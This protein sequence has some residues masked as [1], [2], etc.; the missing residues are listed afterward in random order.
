MAPIPT[1]ASR[2]R[3][4]RR[5][6]SFPQPVSSPGQRRPVLP[7]RSHAACVLT[8]LRT[9]R[10]PGS[11]LRAAHPGP[12]LTCNPPRPGG[13]TWSLISPAAARPFADLGAAPGVW[14]AQTKRPGYPR[15]APSAGAR[16]PP[17]PR[18]RGTDRRPAAQS[19]STARGQGARDFLPRTSRTSFGAGPPLLAAGWQPRG[20]GE[21]GEGRGPEAWGQDELTHCLEVD[22]AR[23][24]PRA[25]SG[26]AKLEQVP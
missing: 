2:P 24:N 20:A 22:L 17:G 9:L 6:R 11:V 14:A 13:V 3:V 26:A 8:V 1:R 23:R 16:A 10:A 18:E 7:A 4:P 19:C 5:E 15:A 12:R 25:E 21:R